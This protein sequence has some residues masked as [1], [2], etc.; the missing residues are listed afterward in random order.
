[1]IATSVG[2]TQS[3]RLALYRFLALALY[4]PSE[5][6]V[7]ILESEEASAEFV[8][9]AE[10]LNGSDGARDARA[11]F[12][13]DWQTTRDREQALLDL[14]VEYNR[15]FVGPAS[16]P[17]PPYQSVYDESRPTEEQG[18]VM[19]PTAE[20]VEKAMRAE[21]LGVTLD[22]VELADH[23][24]IELEFMFYLLSRAVEDPDL[25]ALYADRAG[26]F[27]SSHI[28]PWLAK[29][30]ARVAKEAKHPFYEHAGL[31]LERFIAAE[32]ASK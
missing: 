11:L 27:R 28:L 29:F 22:H 14:Q 26:Q 30:G 1:M 2:A 31:L 24:A 19:G 16:P 6:L 8:R 13:V 32:L 20:A 21:G 4:E 5:S 23:A 9:A 17:C 15:L 18:T 3:P 7:E 10:E 25:G 12:N